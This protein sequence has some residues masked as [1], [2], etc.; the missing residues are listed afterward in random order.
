MNKKM[1][2]YLA[3]SGGIGGAK[4]ALGLSHALNPAQLTVV[5]NTGDDF[6]HHGLNISPDIDT[7]LYTLADLNNTELGWGR[8]DETWGFAE[9][10]EQLGM[11]TWFRLGD[12]DLAI[13]LYR[14]ERIRQG[15]SLSEVIN[16][17]RVKFKVRAE[18]VPMSDTSVST[19]VESDIGT[20][21]FQEY[22]VK[23]RCKPKVSKI[24][25]AG[26]NE[27]MPAPAFLQT[28]DDEELQAIIICP[29]NPFL[30]IDPILCLPGIKEKI[31]KSAKPVLVVSPVVDGQSLK[32]PTAKLMHELNFSCDVLSIAEI[33]HDIAT[34]IIIDTSDKLAIDKIE[35]LGLSVLSTNIIM[36]ELEEKIELG[37]QLIELCTS[38]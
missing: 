35:S 12:K 16:E 3:I 11:D 9:A 33:Y 8:R 18:I 31:K 19:I 14:T 24:H 13:H 1:G 17:L 30:S 29:S 38:L 21:S 27:A 37:R 36:N 20:L 7:L 4:L 26:I 10:C 25:F 5:A 32:G 23:N 34:A 6:I 2:K 28:L 15:A 22:F